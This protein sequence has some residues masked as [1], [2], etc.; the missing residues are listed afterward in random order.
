MPRSAL[1][2]RFWFFRA[3]RFTM[4]YKKEVKWDEMRVILSHDLVPGEPLFLV[5]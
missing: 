2:L 5:V 4:L 1:A 3:P